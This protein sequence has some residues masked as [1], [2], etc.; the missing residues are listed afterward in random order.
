[1]KTEDLS[2]YAKIT[3]ILGLE[4]KLWTEDT[5]T[6]KDYF[7]THLK[8]LG[9]SKFK[10]L[11]ETRH[12]LKSELADKY[13]VSESSVTDVWSALDPARVQA[14]L[15]HVLLR[16]PYSEFQD[17]YFSQK[18][19]GR[20]GSTRDYTAKCLQI[21]RTFGF[22][23]KTGVESWSI[24]QRRI[25]KLYPKIS[26][27]KWISVDRLTDE[28]I[29]KRADTLVDGFYVVRALPYRARKNRYA[30]DIEQYGKRAGEF[31]FCIALESLPAG[32]VFK[33][34]DLRE[35]ADYVKKYE[36]F[37]VRK[38]TTEI[39]NPARL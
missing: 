1:M 26:G 22:V 20:L 5:F 32:R 27:L 35:L 6:S 17:L 36:G 11:R 23:E 29:R 12:L 25:P 21:L 9:P 24:N 2:H 7:E 39:I 3:F 16:L 13:G 4:D 19:S 8:R 38:Y 30:V 15:M 34:T 18:L 31:P 14:R 28:K 37:A 10:K 33:P